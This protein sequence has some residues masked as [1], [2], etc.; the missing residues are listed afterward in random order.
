MRFTCYGGVLALGAPIGWFLLAPAFSEGHYRLYLY[1][2]LTFGTAL[3]FASFGYVLGSAQ[4]FLL[5]IADQDQL[6][7]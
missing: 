1:L 3:A 6:T 2:Y 5:R 4:D 7:V